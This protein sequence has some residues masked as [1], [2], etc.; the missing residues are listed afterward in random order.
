M[1]QRSPIDILHAKIIQHFIPT[2]IYEE[3]KRNTVLRT[4]RSNERLASFML[5]IREAARLLKVP[6]TEDELVKNILIRLFP[7]ERS[8]LVLMN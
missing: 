3:L 4:Q 7:K 5:D 6:L 1:N 2:G 8:R